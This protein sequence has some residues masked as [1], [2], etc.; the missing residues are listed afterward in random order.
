[1]EEYARIRIAISASCFRVRA[2]F[3]RDAFRDECVCVSA[4]SA[5]PY[6]RSSWQFPIA[7]F[8]RIT[9]VHIKYKFLNMQNKLNEADA[10]EAPRG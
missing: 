3:M 4:V 6:P 8:V 2:D 5:E 10:R 7:S 9:F 1:M